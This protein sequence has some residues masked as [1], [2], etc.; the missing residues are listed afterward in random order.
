MLG[1][2]G[3]ALVNGGYA[4]VESWVIPSELT[5]HPWRGILFATLCASGIF[6][7]IWFVSQHLLSMSPFRREA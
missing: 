7:I 4:V 6:A 3:A 5:Q 2:L 1:L